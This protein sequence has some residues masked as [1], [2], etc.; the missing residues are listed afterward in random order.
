[1]V[2]TVVRLLLSDP[3]VGGG[4]SLGLGQVSATHPPIHPPTQP[5]PPPP[6]GGG[7]WWPKMLKF[8]AK[9]P[10]HLYTPPPP[11]GGD[12]SPTKQ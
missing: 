5:Y 6:R 4:V 2:E 12:I 10:T 8:G 1:M 7:A 3:G 9:P 11:R